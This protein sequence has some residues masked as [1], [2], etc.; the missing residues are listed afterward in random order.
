MKEVLVTATRAMPLFGC[1]PLSQSFTSCV[2]SITRYEFAL[3]GVTPVASGTSVSGV[4][5][6]MLSSIHEPVMR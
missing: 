4:A 2:R 6:V 5:D 3:L 1:A